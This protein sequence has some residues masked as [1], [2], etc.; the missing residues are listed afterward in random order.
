MKL[1]FGNAVIAVTTGMILALVAFAADSVIN[2]AR[3]RHWGCRSVLWSTCEDHSGGNCKNL[4]G[5]G[6]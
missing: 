4:V 2:R 6:R 3:I 5:V 1:Y